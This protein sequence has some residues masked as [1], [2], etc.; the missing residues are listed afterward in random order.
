MHL[1]PPDP[2]CRFERADPF[3][4]GPGE[5]DA[6]LRTLI[7]LSSDAVLILNEDGAIIHAS[8]A[9]GRCLDHATDGLVGHRLED[10]ADLGRRGFGGLLKQI[11]EKRDQPVPLRLKRS[12]GSRLHLEVRGA[13]TNLLGRHMLILKDITQQAEA[14]TALRL[15]EERLATALSIGGM[16]AYAVDLATE[17]VWWSLEMYQLL[18]VDPNTYVPSRA[19]FRSLVH[20]DDW[21]ELLANRSSA[22]HT[23]KALTHQFRI[24]RADGEVR[25]LSNR[26]KTTY[27]ENGVPLRH[28]GVAVDVTEQRQSAEALQEQARQLHQADDRKNQF[29]AMLAHELRGPLAPI[30]NA[31]FVLEITKGA[32]PSLVKVGAMIDRHV[33]HLTRLVDDLLD[34][35]RVATGKVRLRRE[36]TDLVEVLH[37]ALEMSQTFIDI[38]RHTFDVQVPKHAIMVDGDATRLAQVV[39]NLLDNAAKYTDEGGHLSLSLT[40][41]H[42]DREQL[43]AVIRVK[44]DGRG[45][46]RDSLENLFELFYQ[47]D[48]NLDRSEG[49]L[50]IGLSLVRELVHMHNGEIVANSLGL[51]LGSEFVVSLPVAAELTHASN[52][53]AWAGIAA[54]NDHAAVVL[55]IDDSADTAE[56]LALL[57]EMAGHEVHTA[58]DGPSGIEMARKVNPSLILLDL[59][60]PGFDGYA[61]CA[62]LRQ[63]GM[64]DSRIVALTGHGEADARERTTAAGFNDHIVKPIDAETLERLV[65]SH[66]PK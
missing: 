62:E 22:I 20:P 31:A 24:N 28:V 9:A 41:E 58:G 44:D 3:S 27:D 16:G 49:G 26:A 39:C 17:T 56:S 21:D 13:P 36:P 46:S 43:L 30:R 37:H 64:A 7:E 48:R 35:A 34:M 14:E 42:G 12:N 38:K 32:D 53:D 65:K 57:L 6:Y 25:W 33:R 63:T 8:S 15:S 47:A 2:F 1:S 23:G 4:L 60:L 55:I 40:L 10:L 54:S 29:L 59:G 45:I 18:H 5:A 19:S 52:Q 61:V 11:G 66:R 50:G 51:G